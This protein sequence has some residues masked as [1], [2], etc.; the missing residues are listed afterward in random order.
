M[1]TIRLNAVQIYQILM[2][3]LLDIIVIHNRLR[4]EQKK[5]FFLNLTHISYICPICLKLLVVSKTL[6]FFFV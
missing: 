2:N 6:F 3:I 4:K 1:E 5:E